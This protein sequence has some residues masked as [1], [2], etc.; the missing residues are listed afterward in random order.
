MEHAMVD[1]VL[2]VCYYIV[3]IWTRR[4]RDSVVGIA[5]SYGQDE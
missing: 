1:L 3:S 4:S 5:T 2:G